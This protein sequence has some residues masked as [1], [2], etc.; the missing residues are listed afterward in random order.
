MATTTTANVPLKRPPEER[1]GRHEDRD[2]PHSDDRGDREFTNADWQKARQTTDP[3]RRRRIREILNETMLPNL[4]RKAGWHRC[5]VSTS[6]AL[7]T[8]QRRQRLGYRFVQL[9]DLQ[10]E[11]AGWTA[12]AESIKDGAAMGAVR[13]REMVGM[14]IPEDEW[15]DIMRELHHDMPREMSA[16][17]YEDLQALSATARDKGGIIDLDEGFREMQKFVRAPRQFET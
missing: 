8:P 6:H 1:L 13:W 15:L 16:G 14:E 17:I 5:W 4:P 2:A 7:D 11:G 12:S 3:E 10:K 9:D